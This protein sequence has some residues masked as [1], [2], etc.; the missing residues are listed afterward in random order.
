MD[1]QELVQHFAEQSHPDELEQFDRA[2]LEELVAKHETPF[3]VLDLEEVD[4]QYK[5]LQAA[6]PGVKLF[7]ALKSLSHPELIKRL[8]GLGCHFDLATI[9]EVD[10][11]ES[12]GI[13][14][15]RCIH[16]HP[17]KKD[18]EIKRALEF[19]CKRFVVDNFEEMKKFY[20]YAGQVELIIR[21][22]FRSKQAV[23]DLSRKFGCSLEELPVLVEMAQ[24]NGIE[25][26]GLS[27]HVGSQS[28]SPATQVNAIR[29]SVAAMKVMNNVKWKFLDI[30]G[31]FP[32]SY[33]E[34]V[35]PIEEFCAPVMEALSELPEH[36]EVF[37]EPGRFISAP[38][39]IE[40]VSVVGKAKRGSRT[41][42]YLD[43]GVYGGFSGQMFDHASYPIAP[44]KPFDPL[45][46]FYPSVLAGPTCDSID[47][48][49][50]D[51]ELPE[52]E[53]GDILIG[54]QMGAYT[55]ASATEFNYYPK[56]KIV[57]VEDIFDP[58]TE[59]L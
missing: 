19:G 8:K 35:T 13:K 9:G 24:S 53:V 12:L 59:A 29:S 32:V 50:E 48:V 49:A 23:V 14:G 51:I 57:V 6:L 39:M 41:W 46:E 18:K 45:G 4:Y 38:S 33:Q 22:S 3:M 1:S 17:I 21:V 10:L 43:D 56:P 28:L 58:T 54:K 27:F 2:S 16:T 36:I 25:V 31:S 40:V 11:V 26:V 5:S 15:D 42:Y 44:L 30:G 55:I 47:V 7:Y 37:A 20:K 52:L 34:E